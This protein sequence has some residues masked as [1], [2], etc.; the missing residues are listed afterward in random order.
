M[1]A[2]IATGSIGVEL[3]SG[4]NTCS[5]GN[6][7]PIATEKSNEIT[8][9]MADSTGFGNFFSTAHACK[10][11]KSDSYVP[12]PPPP[13][14]SQPHTC[15]GLIHT[16]AVRSSSVGI[17][18]YMYSTVPSARAKLLARTPSSAPAARR[19]E[20]WPIADGAISAVAI[21]RIKTTSS[22]AAAAH[23]A[24]TSSAPV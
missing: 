12:A 19:P 20:S 17:P 1:K 18:S 16:D 2:P 3:I 6:T 4:T 14:G 21:R 24:F 9:R 11:S 23:G 15:A 22:N 10:S 5:G 13:F 8:T 7:N